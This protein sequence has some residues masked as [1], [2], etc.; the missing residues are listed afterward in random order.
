MMKMNLKGCRA[1]IS[2]PEFERLAAA[3]EGY[4][5]ADLKNLTKE[6]AM[7]VVAEIPPTELMR[8]QK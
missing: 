6:A 4:S 7:G 1:K 8:V 3:T 2:K 5:N